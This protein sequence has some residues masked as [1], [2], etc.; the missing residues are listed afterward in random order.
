M[1]SI[2]LFPLGTTLFPGGV[3]SLRVFEVRYLDMIKRCIADGSPFGVVALLQ[4]SE[5]R[6]PEG[7]EELADYGS[8]ARIEKSTTPMPGVINLR[9]TGTA[10]FKILGSEVGKFGRWQ[11]TVTELASDPSAP[12][13]AK[14]QGAAT[15]LGKFIASLQ[16]DRVPEDE[17]PLARPFFLDE[18]GWVANRW[19][20]LL[21]LP[22]QQKQ[23]LLAMDDPVQRLT[24]IYEYLLKAGLVS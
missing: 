3:L 13:P 20:E 14:L 23:R 15:H 2:P 19:A 9:C 7:Q 6:T 11:A 12:I 10:R 1:T 8:L 21:P 22:V 18:S 17:M 4:G 24:E 5:V 16:K